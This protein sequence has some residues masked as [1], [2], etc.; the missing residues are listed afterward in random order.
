MLTPSTSDTIEEPDAPWTPADEI[1]AN[2]HDDTRY[3]IDKNEE[4]LR[5]HAER[6]DWN[7]TV[8]TPAMYRSEGPRVIQFGTC[9]AEYEISPLPDGR[10]AM[11]S[12]FRT[13]TGGSHCGWSV[14]GTRHEAVAGF[15]EAALGWFSP[16]SQ[17]AFLAKAERSALPRLIERLSRANLFGFEEPEPAPRE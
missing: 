2:V 11:T 14:Y 4:R 1:R 8:R 16:E 7:R 10:W 5:L 6:E 9:R 17:A 15:V 13:S 3:I 12:D